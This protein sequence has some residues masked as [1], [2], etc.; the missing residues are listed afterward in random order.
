M[1]INVSGGVADDNE[2]KIRYDGQTALNVYL[3]DHKGWLEAEL[4][5]LR[6]KCRSGKIRLLQRVRN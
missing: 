3:S 4:G 5:E 1:Q 6:W 2:W